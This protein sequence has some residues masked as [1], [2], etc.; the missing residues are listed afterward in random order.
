MTLPISAT[1]SHQRM[2]FEQIAVTPPHNCVLHATCTGYDFT[3][4]VIT[5]LFDV[6]LSGQ[7]PLVFTPQADGTYQD[8]LKRAWK[9]IN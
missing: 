2:R 9:L 4:G 6:Q 7:E 1:G 8:Q 3:T 5:A